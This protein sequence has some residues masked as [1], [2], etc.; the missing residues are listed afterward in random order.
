[1]E[2]EMA[3]LATTAAIATVIIEAEKQPRMA[4]SFRLSRTGFSL[5]VLLCGMQ[6]EPD[7]LR[8]VSLLHYCSGFSS[9]PTKSVAL[10]FVA[11]LGPRPSAKAR[12]SVRAPS[13]S[14]GRA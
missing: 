2:N 11:G 5:S 1:M 14:D 4:A 3:A 8:P 12:S 13:K 6:E 9:T 7:R 10:S